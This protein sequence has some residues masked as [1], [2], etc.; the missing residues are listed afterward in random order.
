GERRSVR[1]FDGCNMEET[2]RSSLKQL[3]PYLEHGHFLSADRKIDYSARLGEVT[4]PALMIAGDGD[5]MSDVPSTALTFRALG[6]ADKALLRY[7]KAEGHVADYCHCDLV[8][9]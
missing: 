7:G 6:S 8:W 2:G 4:V 5:V 9:S 3:D 1:G